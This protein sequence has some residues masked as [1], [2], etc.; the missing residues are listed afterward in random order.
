MPPN[1]HPLLRVFKTAWFNKVA[2]K[3]LITDTELCEAIREVM[4][5]QAD[6]LG[7]GVFK[8]RLKDNRFRSLILA[9]SDT[10]WVY[11]YLFAKA[12]RENI[13]VAE[14]QAF[15]KLAKSYDGLT[16]LQIQALIDDQHF[17]EL[18]L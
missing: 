8:K 1:T 14:L 13:D 11:E 9:K 2:K 17:Y 10:F 5:G 6:D 7:G 12:D 15:R 16:E 18:P 4:L 3:A